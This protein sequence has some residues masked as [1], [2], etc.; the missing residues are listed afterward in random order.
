MKENTIKKPMIAAIILQGIAVVIGLVCFLG[1]AGF[2]AMRNVRLTEKVF[3]DS[4]MT[5]MIVLLMHIIC[6]LVMQTNDSKS[7][8][9]IGI[10]MTVVY[11][12]VNILSTY[13]TRMSTFFDSIRGVEYMAAKSVL[14]STVSLITSPLCFISLALALIAIGRFGILDQETEDQG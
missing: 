10:I 13:I 3:P 6:L 11:C 2:G 4:L 14:N 5:L 7:N 8:R 1:Q 9:T 12:V